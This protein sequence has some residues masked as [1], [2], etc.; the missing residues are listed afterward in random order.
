MRTVLLAVA[1]LVAAAAVPSAP[2]SA[3]S[4]AD[5]GFTSP[6]AGQSPS[7]RRG[8]DG[9]RDGDRRRHRRGDTVIVDSG[10]YYGG[11][12]ALHN[13]RGWEPDS[14]NDWWHERPERAFPRWMQTG[15]C[16]RA[17]WAGN[18]LRCADSEPPR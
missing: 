9:W 3:Q 17:W 15:T 12:W 1:G 4:F 14:Y 8:G 5:V 6:S 7:F 18:V 13:N 10:G 11:E 16:D 2:A